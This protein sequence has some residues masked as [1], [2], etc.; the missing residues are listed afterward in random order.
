[1]LQQEFQSWMSE[2]VNPD[3]PLKGYV[4]ITWEEEL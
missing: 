4:L 2:P 3:I 1:M